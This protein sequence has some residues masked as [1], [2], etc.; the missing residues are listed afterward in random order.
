MK[1]F[2]KA[3]VTALV[4][5]LSF[6]LMTGLAGCSAKKTDIEYDDDGNI[7]PGSSVSEVEFWGW[8]DKEEIEVFNKLV[9]TFNKEYEGIIK[10]N[11]VQKNSQGYQDA[12]AT[13][14]LGSRPADVVYA[15]DGE[16]KSLVDDGSLLDLSEMLAGSKVLKEEDMWDSAINRFR[17]DPDTTTDTDING[18]PASVWGIPKDIGPTVLYYNQTQFE[19]AGVTVISVPEDELDAYNKEKGTA[20]LK[21]GYQ[22]IA[23]GGA[24]FNNRI[25]MSWDETRTLSQRVQNGSS[26]DYGYFTEWWF[27]YGWSVGGDCIEYIPTSDA[28]YNGGYWDFT[29][30]DATKN[31][32]VAD[33]FEGTYTVNNN[34]YKAGEIIAWG[35]KLS[36]PAADKT[37]IRPQILS[38]LAAGKL[39]ELPSQREAFTEFVRLSQPTD[40]VVDKVNG[41]ELKGYGITPNPTTIST[42]GKVGFF[43][44]QKLSMLVDGRWSVV[45]I[46]NSMPE[47]V[48]WD[49]APLPVYKRYDAQG[50]VEAHGV[51]SGHSGSTS[52]AIAKKSKVP[53]AAWAFIEYVSGP[54]GQS[55]QAEAGFAIPNQK[56][57]ANTEAFLQSTKMPKNSIVFIEAAEVQTPGDWWYLKNKKWIDDWANLLNGD[58]RNGKITLSEFFESTQYTSTYSKLLDYTK[59]K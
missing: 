54:E 34:Q 59:K 41:Q 47:G 18:D 50:N 44:S 28:A 40:K 58:V 15:G 35:D 52:L 33:D 31:Y 12:V 19:A 56:S 37:T 36:N 8:G 16:Y 45:N 24:V 42:D 10:V 20:Y 25:A 23:G 21:K 7:K 30:A 27:A 5:A 49:V 3:I 32:I 22:E 6:S 14:L 39:N 13:N 11:Y 2:K 17:Y 1:I 46:R 4:L 48:V 29:L 9:D 43:T 38:D 53:K 26:A 57:V 55:I 51:A